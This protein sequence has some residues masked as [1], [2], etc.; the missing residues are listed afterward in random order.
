[1][2]S[3]NASNIRV[4][5]RSLNLFELRDNMLQNILRYEIE[6]ERLI[7]ILEGIFLLII[8]KVFLLNL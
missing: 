8:I 4:F 1:M 6:P 7:F 3:K 5:M 2:A